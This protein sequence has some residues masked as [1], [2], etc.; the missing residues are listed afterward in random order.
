MQH[1]NNY[2]PLLCLTLLLSVGGCAEQQSVRVS[3][4]STTDTA[5]VLGSNGL[6]GDEEQAILSYHNQIRASVGVPPLH[7]SKELAQHAANWGAKLAAQGCAMQHSQDSS[8]GENLFISSASQDHEAVIEAAKAWESEKINYSGEPLN[9]A[10]WSQ[11]GHYTQ[12]VWRDTAQ[13]GCA[14]VACNSG[15]VVV[16][17]YDPAGNFIGKKPY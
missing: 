12:M 17:N 2:L 7:W 6:D 15:V 8:Y 9:K 4:K 3:Q 11:S 14:K 13:L 1:R 10:N 5:H 16:C